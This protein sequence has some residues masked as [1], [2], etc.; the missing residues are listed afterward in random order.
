M[1][2]TT[3]LEQR[4]LKLER[5]Q[6]SRLLVNRAPVLEIFYVDV[7]ADGAQVGEPEHAYTVTPAQR[8]GVVVR[9]PGGRWR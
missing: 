4:L 7:D 5:A 6:Q 1:A 2:T 3:N 9:F 8:P